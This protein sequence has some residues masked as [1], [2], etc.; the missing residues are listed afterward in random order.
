[1]WAILWRWNICGKLPNWMWWWKHHWR[2]WLFID[3][4]NWGGFHMQ[5]WEHHFSLSLHIHW[6]PCVPDSKIYWENIRGESGSVQVRCESSS[7]H[8]IED[9]SLFKCF[10]SLWCRAHSD[11]SELLWWCIVSGDWLLNWP[12]V[13]NL[14]LNNVFRPK[15]DRE[16]HNFTAIHKL[17][18]MTC[19]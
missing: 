13:A 8:N 1:M 7:P 3:M 17:N 15:Y 4:L 5:E 19:H 11:F 12:W 10:V 2:R 14:Q 9:G 6:H 18:L 16:Q